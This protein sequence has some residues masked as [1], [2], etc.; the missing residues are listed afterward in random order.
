M[1]AYL[2]TTAI[3]FGLITLVHIWR[4]IAESATLA[5]DPWFVLIT[6]LAAALCLWAF[7][8]LRRS[9]PGSGQ[10]EEST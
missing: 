2:L 4:A 8:L 6:A 9:A 10:R 1:K 3:L 7:R 5:R